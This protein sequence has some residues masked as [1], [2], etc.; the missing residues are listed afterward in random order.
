MPVSA[1]PS[2]RVGQDVSSP[3]HSKLIK[4]DVAQPKAGTSRYIGAKA[5]AAVAD[6]QSTIVFSWSAAV[7]VS[8]FAQSAVMQ[9][10]NGCQDKSQ[11]CSPFSAVAFCVK[12]HSTS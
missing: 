5:G 11:T 3:V 10:D 7:A 12:V 1:F 4:L 8:A 2:E 6:A 9:G